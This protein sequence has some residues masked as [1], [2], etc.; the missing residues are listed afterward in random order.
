MPDASG[1]D[2]L[3]AREK[4]E[5]HNVGGYKFVN[6]YFPAWQIVLHLV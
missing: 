4:G 6:A 3:V 1:Y 5:R 2:C